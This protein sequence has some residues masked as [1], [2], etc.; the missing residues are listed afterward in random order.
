[1]L[2]RLLCQSAA[3]LWLVQ[4]AHTTGYF[5]GVLNIRGKRQNGG[6]VG[7]ILMP[8]KGVG[9]VMGLQKGYGTKGYGADASMPL[10]KG[11]VAGLN[12]NG[13]KG[14][15][16]SAAFGPSGPRL[17]VKGASKDMKGFGHPHYRSGPGV[18]TFRGLGAP[19][20]AR[21]QE[22]TY[23][24]NKGY[25]GQTMGGH[26][27]GFTGFPLGSQHENGGMKGPKPGYGY[28]PWGANKSLKSGYITAPRVTFTKG[29]GASS[30][31]GQKGEV[32]SPHQIW[33]PQEGVIPP[34]STASTHQPTVRLAQ[35]KYQKL[36][37][38]TLRGKRYK[39]PHL[40]QPASPQPAL[41]SP[42]SATLGGSPQGE[43]L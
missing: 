19:H 35:G 11:Y 29:T 32:L 43:S 15:G 3:V 9:Q 23:G 13:F 26:N 28:S 34:P 40:I 22:K 6:G 8:S 30:G 37:L 10:T 2:G 21:R 39:Q 16:H 24:T 12:G 4:T 25:K 1:M 5:S 33:T 7:G 41:T 14:D 18:G 42:D 20:P 38:T 31:K 27:G 36:P 17:N